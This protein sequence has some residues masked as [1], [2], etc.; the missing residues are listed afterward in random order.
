MEPLITYLLHPTKHYKVEQNQ[1]IASK[2]C[3]LKQKKICFETRSS[4]GSLK[5][6]KHNN[7]NNETFETLAQSRMFHHHTH[8]LCLQTSFPPTS[9][10]KS[11]ALGDEGV[12][13]GVVVI[14]LWMKR[15]KTGQRE[16]QFKG[17]QLG[18]LV[19]EPECKTLGSTML[20]RHL[21]WR[22]FCSIRY[23]QGLLQFQTTGTISFLM[24]I[25][26]FFFCL[27]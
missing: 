10:Q 19:P 8:A 5:G 14:F 1:T 16:E 24:K 12:R 18:E 15:V 23:S 20:I 27:C 4:K 25:K 11:P 3:V 2:K 21:G 22:V 17:T 13:P 26:G 9:C 7:N 6:G